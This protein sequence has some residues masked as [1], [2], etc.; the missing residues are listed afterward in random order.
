[1]FHQIKKTI[2]Y[3]LL[4][5]VPLLILAMVIWT[6]LIDG[7]LYYSSDKIPLLDF[8]P[9]FVH[10]FKYGDYYI[11]SPILVWGIW[12]SLVGLVITIPLL[13]IKKLYKIKILIGLLFV[14]LIVFY[15][16]SQK[17]SQV[18]P[19]KENLCQQ[20]AQ[21]YLQ[22]V[23]KTD[24][25]ISSND[26]SSLENQKWLMAID[27]ETELYNMCLLDLNPASLKNY[28]LDSFEK[29]R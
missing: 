8:I 4:F 25:A 29:Y 17:H 9:P 16:F 15:F 20:F 19:S 21:S 11:V 10:N 7:N 22:T 24:G 3:Y 13:I 26:T 12:F 28:K 5:F 18:Y 1:M 27:V 23:P 6:F 2:F 14:G